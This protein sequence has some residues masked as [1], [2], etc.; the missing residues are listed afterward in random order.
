[1]KWWN[2]FWRS[3]VRAASEPIGR[4]QLRLPGWNEDTPAEDMRI[5]RDLDGD[6]LSLAISSEPFPYFDRAEVMD[7]RKWARELAQGNG[8]G[9]IE[10]CRLNEGGKIIYKRLQM[11]AYVYSG[12]LLNRM[13]EV[14]LA[15]TVVAGERG[16]TGLREAIVTSNLISEGKLKPEEYEERWGQDP[17]DPAF[18]SVVDRS[19]LR[20]ISDDE[21]YDQQFPRHPLSKVRQTLATIAKNVDYSS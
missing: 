14:W 21:S 9:L 10:A 20:F 15:W 13:H 19:L 2:H 7:I 12:M 18:R 17:Y 16:V 5:W 4:V 1:M 8:G 3:S 6:V 11:P